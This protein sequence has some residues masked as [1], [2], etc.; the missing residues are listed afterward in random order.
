MP[1]V[2]CCAHKRGKLVKR[3]TVMSRVLSSVGVVV[4]SS[5]VILQFTHGGVLEAMQDFTNSRSAM[6]TLHQQEDCSQNLDTQMQRVTQKLEVRAQV[7]ECWINGDIRLPQVIQQF[8]ATEELFPS[9]PA[10][11]HIMTIS[12]H[13]NP[14]ERLAM[15]ALQFALG[16]LEFS[17]SQYGVKSRLEAEFFQ[18]FGHAPKLHSAH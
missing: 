8:Q 1:T 7:C 16:Q 9:K 18:R 3:A 10:P 5:A 17:K 6:T 13:A 4:M 12:T 2:G 11:A 14:D 15:Q